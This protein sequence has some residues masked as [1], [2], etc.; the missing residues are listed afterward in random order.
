MVQRISCP[1]GIVLLAGDLAAFIL[2]TYYGKIAHGLPTHWAG[3]LETMAPFLLGW[4]SAGLLLQPYRRET[5]ERAARQLGNV[6]V[7]WTLAAPIG[8]LIRYLWQGQPPTWLFIAVAYFV[9]LAFLLAWRIPFA[10]A[11]AWRR[12]R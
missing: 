7:M 5:L 10:A 3:I 12:R 8:I 1:A 11:Y 9:M 2:F 4:I 6:L